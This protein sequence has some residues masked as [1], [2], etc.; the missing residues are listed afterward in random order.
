M[1]F[2]FRPIVADGPV[3]VE[4]ALSTSD[5]PPAVVVS[6]IVMP[7]MDGR[8]LATSLRERFPAIGVVLTSGYDPEAETG[9]PF[10]DIPGA[11]FVPK[12]FEAGVL[13]AA[14][15]SVLAKPPR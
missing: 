11:A 2:G 7:G 6:D 5:V 9:Q 13:A 14:V 8:T 10:R 12:P 15:A 3:D 4:R 1:R